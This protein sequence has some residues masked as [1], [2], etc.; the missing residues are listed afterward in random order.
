MYVYVYNMYAC[1]TIIITE[2]EVMN[3]KE[4]REEL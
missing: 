2:E 3:L 1:V 4:Y